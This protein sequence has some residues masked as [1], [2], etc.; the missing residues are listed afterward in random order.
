MI[1]E[2]FLFIK[3]FLVFYVFLIIF[4]VGFVFPTL[5]SNVAGADVQMGGKVCFS[6]AGNMIGHNY[7]TY[8]SIDD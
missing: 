5:Q 8:H 3:L 6:A 4:F 1:F 2:M 7:G